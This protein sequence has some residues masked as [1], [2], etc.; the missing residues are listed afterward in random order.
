VKN[1]PPVCDPN[2]RDTLDEATIWSRVV[3]ARIVDMRQAVC[4]HAVGAARDMAAF[5]TQYAYDFLYGVAVKQD[6]AA[7]RSWAEKAAAQGNENAH[8]ILADIYFEGLGVPQDSAKVRAWNAKR[9][10]LEIARERKVVFNLS[11]DEALGHCVDDWG[12]M[13]RTGI[14]CYKVIALDLN[15]RSQAVTGQIFKSYQGDKEGCSKKTGRERDEC[16]RDLA[17]S[18]S[19]NSVGSFFDAAA[20]DARIASLR[21]LCQRNSGTT[22][23]NGEVFDAS[24]CERAIRREMQ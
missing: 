23:S 20:L 3:G 15:G 12:R 19:D 10:D 1:P 2:T 14:D 21:K 8:F 11:I 5:Q 24:R 7:A 6:Y 13:A 18:E 17:G 4:W 9:A 22:L 16:Y